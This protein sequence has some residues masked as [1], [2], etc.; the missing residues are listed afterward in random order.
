MMLLDPEQLRTF[1]AFAETGSLARAAAAVN[2]SP[3]AVSTQMQ[4]LEESVGE[5][6]LAPDGRGRAL[7]PTGQ[8]L[9]SHARRILDA[10]AQAM[11]SLKGA[12]AEGRVAL[13][14]TQDFAES[15]LPSLLALFARTHARIRVDLRIGRSVEI[16]EALASGAV[17][18][19]IAMRAGPSADEV[20]AIV[21]ETVWWAG[22]AGPN[23]FGDGVALALLDPPCGFR[24]RALDALDR[25]GRPYRIAATS[26]SLAGLRTAVLAGLAVT[27]RTGRWLGPGLIK[28]PPALALPGCS[29]G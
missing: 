20:T 27:L 5:P 6:L 29:S 28:A 1:L 8:E 26:Q 17:D 24:D 18:V 11:L 15:G 14:A 10:H 7:T 23:E 4:K 13:A 16:S 25:I 12:R 19:G 21:E 3:S 2:R 22:V 9:V